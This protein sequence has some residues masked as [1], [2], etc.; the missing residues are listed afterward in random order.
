[1]APWLGGVSLDGRRSI[2]VAQGRQAV[3]DTVQVNRGI[4]RRVSKRHRFC[5][6]Q[7]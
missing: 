1:M 7:K 4:E 5:L 6:I 3:S 2:F